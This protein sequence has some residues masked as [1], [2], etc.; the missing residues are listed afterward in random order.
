MGGAERL[1]GR[2]LGRLSDVGWGTR[3][4]ALLTSR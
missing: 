1:R 2:A 3:L 4:R